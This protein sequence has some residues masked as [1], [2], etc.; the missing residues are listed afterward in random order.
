MP[1]P[2]AK[3]DT[4]NERDATTPRFFRFQKR[5]RRR[6]RPGDLFVMRER[7]DP[8]RY[9]HGLVVRTDADI[10]RTGHAGSLIYLFNRLTDEPR[11]VDDPIATMRPANLLLP[12][13]I[14]N[15]RPWTM[16]LFRTIDDD[17]YS[18][19][20]FELLDPHIFDAV[21]PTSRRFVNEHGD[22]VD[23]ETVTAMTRHMTHHHPRPFLEA[24]VVG[25]LYIDELAGEALGWEK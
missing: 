13:I 6:P 4:D 16:G 14:T 3:N 20:D 1:S 7:A 12:P 23:A 22:P 8:G 10:S 18:I 21:I 24:G 17:S 2:R 9:L 5:S 25:Y 15:R 19:D 11:P